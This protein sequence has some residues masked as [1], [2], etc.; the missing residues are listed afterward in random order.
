[1]H[2][3]IHSVCI[4]HLYT[5]LD[6]LAPV[7]S[8]L[9]LSNYKKIGL[10]KFFYHDIFHTIKHIFYFG[11]WKWRK[12]IQKFLWRHTVAPPVCCVLCFFVSI[13]R[14]GHTQPFL[15]F[16]THLDHSIWDGDIGEKTPFGRLPVSAIKAYWPLVLSKWSE[17]FWSYF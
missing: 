17:K 9:N 16:F 4:S 7:I 10:R 2:R 11:T 6:H 15:G 12:C 14:V 3:P 1:M 5:Y 8:H 13:I